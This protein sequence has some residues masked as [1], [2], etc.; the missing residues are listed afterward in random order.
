MGLY[1][2][3]NLLDSQRNNQQNERIT[4]R[5]EERIPGGYESVLSLTK[6]QV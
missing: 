1:Q 4:Y 5:I 3:K 2:T 6:A